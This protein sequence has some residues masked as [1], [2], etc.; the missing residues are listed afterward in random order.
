MAYRWGRRLAE[1]RA[2]TVFRVAGGATVWLRKRVLDAGHSLAAASAARI[3]S[4]HA[5]SSAC[6]CVPPPESHHADCR[7]WPVVSGTLTTR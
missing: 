1:V 3:V 2:V 6:R 4:P 5:R 7:G